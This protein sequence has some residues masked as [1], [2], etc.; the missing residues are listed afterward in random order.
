MDIAFCISAPDVS[1]QKSLGAAQL[2]GGASGG[3]CF[4]GWLAALAFV[5]IAPTDGWAHGYAGKRFFPSTLAIEDPFVNDEMSLIGGYFEEAGEG[6]FSGTR[7]TEF[8]GEY[9]KTIFPLFG[10]SLGGG[11]A[12]LDPIGGGDSHSGFGNLEVGLKY[13]FLTSA[14][15]EALMS[16]AVNAE[17]GGTGDPNVEAD[18]YSTISPGLFFGMGMGDLPEAVKYLRPLALTGELIVNVPTERNS[19]EDDEI[20]PN[21]TNLTWGVVVEYS[22]PYLQAFVKDIGLGMPFNRFV[23]LVEVAAATCLD[24]GCG[25]EVVGT[26]N[27]GLIWIGRYLQFG[28]EAQIPINSRTGSSVGFLAQIHLFLDDMFPNSIGRPIFGSYTPRDVNS[29]FGTRNIR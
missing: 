23:P 24:R 17:V 15:H 19:V 28:L 10:L 13:Q 20:V 5:L 11:F 4:I 9:T 18:S 7:A 8:E 14:A 25:G 22:V 26:V 12:H 6:S 16:F 27:P 2:V 29:K 21:P 3:L 1:T